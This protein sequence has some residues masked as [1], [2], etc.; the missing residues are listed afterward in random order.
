MKD[1]IGRKALR[2]SDGNR[3]LFQLL[4]AVFATLFVAWLS[5]SSCQATFINSD[6]AYV[7]QVLSGCF[8]EKPMKWAPFLSPVLSYG[9]SVLYRFLPGIAWYAWTQ[10]LLMIV[11]VALIDGC[12]IDRVAG[13]FGPKRL[14][15]GGLICLGINTLLCWALTRMSVYNTVAI[16]GSAVVCLMARHGF[17]GDRF[18][19]RGVPALLIFSA[20]IGFLPLLGIG[21]FCLLLL[22]A[23]RW[24]AAHVQ[25]YAQSKAVARRTVAFVL[26]VVVL[27]TANISAFFIMHGRMGGEKYDEWE[28]LRRA[29]ARN[30]TVPYGA[31][32]DKYGEAGWSK[33]FR[34]LTA[35][36][37][38]MDERFNAEALGRVLKNREAVNEAAALLGPAEAA[39]GYVD[40]DMPV[41]GL[42]LIAHGLLLLCLVLSA[43][44]KRRR[45]IIP[46]AYL[47]ILDLIWLLLRQ[48]WSLAF[49]EAFACMAPWI[50][51]MADAA[52]DGIGPVLPMA[53]IVAQL[54]RASWKY[55]SAM[56]L[57]LAGCIV[58]VAGCLDL[59]QG[60]EQTLT[61]NRVN[62]VF[63]KDRAFEECIRD[64][65]REH[66]DRLV[67]YHWSN[68]TTFDP[69]Q[70]VGKGEL[71]NLFCDNLVGAYSSPYRTQLRLNGLKKPLRSSDFA[72][73]DVRFVTD[74]QVV[75]ERLLEILS[76]EYGLNACVVEEKTE[77]GIL[78]ARYLKDYDPQKPMNEADLPALAM[79]CDDS[80]TGSKIVRYA[81]QQCQSER[82]DGKV[83]LV[84]ENAF[85][86]HYHIRNGAEA[87]DRITEALL[88]KK[89][90]ILTCRELD[91]T[92]PGYAFT[93]WRMYWP[94]AKAWYV[95]DAEG[96]GK[97]VREL[98]EGDQYVQLKDGDV[99]R[100]T[101]PEGDELHL[102]AQWEKKSQGLISADTLYPD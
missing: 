40:T 86:V 32:A 16:G 51:L 79:V 24:R 78:F 50:F 54:K 9:F 56:L 26:L 11:G 4:I 33:G 18:W 42:A 93:G 64:Y 70:T 84:R 22:S 45:L 94:Q 12:A 28:S 25:L 60:A 91:F 27:F 30:T 74:N 39:N 2:D 97:W 95:T 34:L 69:F 7:A 10:R 65:A 38:F 100:N 59:K 89:T 37:Y 6:E 68:N 44:K 85:T 43:A 77:S 23:M 53:E 46:S 15:V 31:Y 67:V 21:L 82:A 66:R 75:A 57:A 72:R 96:K 98:S 29:Y 13:C 101:I 14:A 8:T 1:Q 19:W 52:M 76:E 5:I 17:E 99:L 80:K 61:A 73:D 3:R 20:C 87:S 41:E 92:K 62:A 102:Y 47:L 90:S 36:H 88:N 35:G 83:R 48:R 55:R 63:E 49:P 81:P 71:Y 58:I